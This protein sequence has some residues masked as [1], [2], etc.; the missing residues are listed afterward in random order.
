MQQNAEPPFPAGTQECSFD[1]ECLLLVF[2]CTSDWSWLGHAHPGISVTSWHSQGKFKPILMCFSSNS[3]CL[4]LGVAPPAALAHLTNTPVPS[5]G[6]QEPAGFLQH[7]QKPL[8][9]TFHLCQPK[10]HVPKPKVLVINQDKR[11][12]NSER[13][14]PANAGSTLISCLFILQGLRSGFHFW[15]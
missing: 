9:A 15:D 12:Q 6:H 2:G 10:I 5:K 11:K 8:R 4:Q 13:G 1:S 3:V 7:K 14:T